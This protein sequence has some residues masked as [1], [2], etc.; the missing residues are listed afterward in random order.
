M[1]QS[2]FDDFVTR[3]TEKKSEPDWE[4]RRD[5]W[6]DELKQLYSRLEKYLENYTKDDRIKLTK[7]PISLREEYIGSYDTEQIDIAIGNSVVNL[8]PIGTLLIGGK[9]RVDMQGARATAKIVLAPEDV[10]RPTFRVITSDTKE[11][12]ASTD[13]TVWAWKIMEY[14]AGL[15]YITLDEK[16]FFDALMTVADA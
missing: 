1:G 15:R 16:T 11:E 10:D 7:R 6:L 9:G 2:A 5:E 4:A 14:S 3:K 8:K 12:K 13:K